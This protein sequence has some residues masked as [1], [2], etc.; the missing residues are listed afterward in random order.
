MAHGDLIVSNQ[1]SSHIKLID[2]AVGTTDGV[3]VDTIDYEN[4]S[5][6]ITL[7]TSGTVQIC[8]SNSPTRPLDS[9]NGTQIGNDFTTQ[10]LQCIDRLPRWLKARVTAVSGALS[11]LTVLRKQ[12]Q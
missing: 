12:A 3:W 6:E 8:G 1:R 9:A 11:V 7:T 4:G 2:A 10:T 5:I